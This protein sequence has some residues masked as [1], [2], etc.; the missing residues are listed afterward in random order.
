VTIRPIRPE[1]E[2]LMVKF[3]GMLSERTVYLR[4]FSPL[5][6]RRRVEHDRL[7]RICFGGYD[8][9]MV[10]VADGKD[11]QS[12]E[13]R[14]LGVGRLNKLRGGRNEGEV[15]VLVAD[16]YQNQGLGRELVRRCL[17]IAREEKL[18]RVV[19]ELLHDNIG[20]QRIFKH[21]GFT[22]GPVEE[23]ESFTASL[24]L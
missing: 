16:Q 18:A 4:Y 21:F 22:F 15:A 14:I 12:N 13:H 9:E 3:H 24:T 20:M 23:S 7:L 2:P 1:D 11:P 17:Q 5:S 6:L 19:A 10:L 8:R